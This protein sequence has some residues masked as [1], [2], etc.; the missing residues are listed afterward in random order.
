MAT[1]DGL[2]KARMLAIEA[3]SITAARIDPVTNHLILTTHGGTDIDVGN[4]Q[5]PQGNQGIQGPLPPVATTVDGPDAF[6]DSAVVGTST[7]YAR[8]DHKHGLPKVG[9]GASYYRA[10]AWVTGAGG[11]WVKFNLDTKVYDDNNLYS[12]VNGV[13][14]IAKAGRYR[15]GGKVRATSNAVNQTMGLSV[16]KNGS[17]YRSGPWNIMPL[18]GAN[19]DASVD[20][21]VDCAVNDTLALWAICSTA[22]LTGGTGSGDA[23]CTLDFLYTP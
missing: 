15:M 8:A 22:N 7:S 11:T 5:G 3:E 23:Y 16:F 20:V 17:L 1:I 4:V 14:T 19:L 10:A 18:S 2:T 6:G 13:F 9:F 12:I 21:T